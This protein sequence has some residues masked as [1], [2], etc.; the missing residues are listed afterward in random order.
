MGQANLGVEAHTL[1]LNADVNP[2]NFPQKD[3]PE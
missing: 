3:H 2:D 1:L